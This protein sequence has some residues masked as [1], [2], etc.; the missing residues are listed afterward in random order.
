MN[1]RTNGETK[2][3]ETLR[4]VSTLDHPFHV[5]PLIFLSL[6][7]ST[8]G[9]I[10]LLKYEKVVHFFTLTKSCNIYFNIVDFKVV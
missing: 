7:C 6:I 5:G 4:R 9:S 10:V 1:G 8:S 2:K 3:R